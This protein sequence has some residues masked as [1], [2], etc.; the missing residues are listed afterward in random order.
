MRP[1]QGLRAIGAS[2]IVLGLLVLS[3]ALGSRVPSRAHLRDLTVA[4]GV[5]FG[6]APTQQLT[7]A[8]TEFIESQLGVAPKALTASDASPV[9]AAPTK[10]FQCVNGHQ[11]ADPL[12]PPC[13]T[14]L[15]TS[16]AGATY[17]GVTSDEIRI[18]V[19]AYGNYTYPCGKTDAPCPAKPRDAP[20][21]QLFDMDQPQPDTLMFARATKDY[22][23][24]FNSRFQT[25]GRHVHLYLYFFNPDSYY[26]KEASKNIAQTVVDETH[27]FAVILQTPQYSNYLAEELARR[28][29]PTFTDLWL[30]SESESYYEQYPGRLIGYWPTIERSAD[31]YASYVCQKVA[32]NPVVMSGNP[33]DN[34]RPRKFGLIYGT[35][36]NYPVPKQYADAVAKRLRACGVD[37]EQGSFAASGCASADLT[38]TPTADALVLSRFKAQGVTTILWPTCISATI[39]VAAEALGYLPEW[40][41]LGDYSFEANGPISAGGLS[42]LFDGHSVVV[43]P[44]T[45]EVPLHQKRCYKSLVEVD[46]AVG[47][48]DAFWMCRSYERFRQLFSAIQLA[49]PSLGPASMHRGLLSAPTSA[50][51]DPLTPACDYAA[52]KGA[53][54]VDAMVM[55]W[56]NHKG[57]AYNQ[58]PTFLSALLL[59]P[60]PQ[61]QGCWRVLDN[62][63]RTLPGQWSKGNVFD[64]RSADDPCNDN[65]ND[66]QLITTPGR[67]TVTAGI[68]LLPDGLP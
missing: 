31:L 33:G 32:P 23:T 3:V 58:S 30:P 52:G 48:Y 59:N 24:Y 19:V 8:S 62:G 9:N 17:Q 26:Q 6:P 5:D 64:T 35:F 45:R 36:H 15:E 61:K 46:P 43:T 44:A 53:C 39:A 40:V 7:G 68:P 66:V 22:A 50:S 55:Y 37:F 56:D 42:V 1:S 11:T 67:Y 20:Y 65:D 34:G 21:N 29:V 12:S 41:L 54:V 16:N 38:H 28:G 57:T 25:F 47:D 60:Q 2:G 13:N 14:S 63:A 10:S 51:P 18:V 49:G 27:P 4:S